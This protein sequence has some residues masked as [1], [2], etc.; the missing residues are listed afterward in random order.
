MWGGVVTLLAASNS[1]HWGPS[2]I[3]TT[4]KRGMH[5]LTQSANTTKQ[6]KSAQQAMFWPSEDEAKLSAPATELSADV[7]LARLP[8]ARCR[9]DS[10]WLRLR[11]CF[12]R[13]D[14]RRWM[15]AGNTKSAPMKTDQLSP[16][17]HK[18]AE[19][20]DMSFS[21]L[22]ITH[23]YPLIPF[24]FPV[25]PPE[26]KKV[27]NNSPC[28]ICINVFLVCCSPNPQWSGPQSMNA[29]QDEIFLIK[30]PRE[31]PMVIKLRAENSRLEFMS[32]YLI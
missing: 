6:S 12:G 27:H 23:H 30:L 7:C 19:I 22:L 3:R 16:L 8:S 32:R 21:F 20:R 14:I 13:L 26:E 31:S 24:L 1:Q 18:S 9:L 2:S 28:I 17:F 5:Q 25:P 4:L 10:L 11:E 15:L 29:L